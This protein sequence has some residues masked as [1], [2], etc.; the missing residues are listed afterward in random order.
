L[1]L[2]KT[3]NL[4][5]LLQYRVLSHEGLDHGFG[6]MA[7]MHPPVHRILG[8]VS[9]PSA[10]RLS[11]DVW[12][13]NQIRGLQEKQIYV[14]G[15]P[16]I[17]DQVTLDRL[18][19]LIDADLINKNGNKIGKI[20]D[21]VFDTTSGNILNYFVSR[22]DPRIPG[23]SRWKLKLNL[24]IDQ[25][26]GY[27]SSNIEYLDDLPLF[28]SSIRQRFLKKSKTL[29]DQFQ[30]LSDKA[31]NKLEGWLE[32]APWEDEMIENSYIDSH[33]DPI[34]NWEEPFDQR[35]N[36]RYINNKEHEND[37]IFD[38]NNNEEDPWI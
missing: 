36:L 2:P 16:S 13:L 22:T 17:S 18:P 10:L 21:F 30:E 14:K 8:W 35:E 29:R 19:T 1:V 26:P 4:S 38:R 7:W 12:S 31:T 23:T 20:A 32:E 24:I 5:D 9:K 34:N 27:V 33:V 37:K 3:L 6:S 15:K 25:K 28:K 11:R